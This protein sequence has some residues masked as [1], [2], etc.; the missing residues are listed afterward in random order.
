MPSIVPVEKTALL[1][2][3]IEDEYTDGVF[4]L[5]DEWGKVK[6][7]TSRLQAEIDLLRAELSK[8]E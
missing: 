3:A 7:N 2:I 1:E 6:I 4:L 8:F 5:I